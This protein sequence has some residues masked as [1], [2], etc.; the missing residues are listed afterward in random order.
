MSIQIQHCLSLCRYDHVFPGIRNHPDHRCFAC[1]HS[2]GLIP[3]RIYRRLHA[4]VFF[5]PDPCNYMIP[6]VSERQPIG[7]D[8]RII[9]DRIRQQLTALF[10]IPAVSDQL[11]SIL[12]GAGHIGSAKQ[13]QLRC[14]FFV[15]RGINVLTDFG[16][17]IKQ[18]SFFFQLKSGAVGCHINS[19]AA[20]CRGIPCDLPAAYCQLAGIIRQAYSAATVSRCIVSDHSA[21]YIPG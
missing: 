6:A 10:I 8:H 12:C 3:D 5:V 14:F 4:V 7:T 21:C 15:I 18:L 19:A 20:I 11:L 1:R 2:R 16:K 9:V 13:L 17:V